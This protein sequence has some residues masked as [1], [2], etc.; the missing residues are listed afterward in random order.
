MS[1][2]TLKVDAYPTVRHLPDTSA[3]F[4]LFPFVSVRFRDFPLSSMW[5]RF[6]IVIFPICHLLCSFRFY[7]FPLL[8][9]IRRAYPSSLLFSL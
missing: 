3:C 9:Y 7:V 5:F 4:R 2:R 8:R 6:V 1:R